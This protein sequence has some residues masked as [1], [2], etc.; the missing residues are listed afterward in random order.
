MTNYRMIRQIYF[1]PVKAQK[2]LM[3]HRRQ[4][5]I[6]QFD[7][8]DGEQREIEAFLVYSETRKQFLLNQELDSI[9]DPDFRCVPL[10]RLK[11][12]VVDGREYLPP[13]HKVV[14]NG[15]QCTSLD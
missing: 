1:D 7:K 5:V 6:V 2:L 8:K 11:K 4:Q 12:L 13:R 10:S 9:T 15:K 3:D 14:S